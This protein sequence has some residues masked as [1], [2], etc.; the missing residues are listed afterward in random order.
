MKITALVPPLGILERPDV[1]TLK[2]FPRRKIL[3]MGGMLA[4]VLLSLSSIVGWDF[5]RKLR[6]A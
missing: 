6:T 3:L 2:S 4:G 5:Y 1:P